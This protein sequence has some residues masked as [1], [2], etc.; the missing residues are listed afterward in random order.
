MFFRGS[1]PSL[2]SEFTMNTMSWI[3]KVGS[4]AVL[5]AQK[6]DKIETIKYSHFQV[7]GTRF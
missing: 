1:D 3:V 4:L 5:V 6:E 7:P 2:F